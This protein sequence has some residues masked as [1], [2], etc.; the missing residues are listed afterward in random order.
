M[1]KMDGKGV[2]KRRPL[3]QPQPCAVWSGRSRVIHQPP[4]QSGHPDGLPS[5]RAPNSTTLFPR[6]SGSPRKS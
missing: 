5:R 6:R 3:A 4:E 1:R 2:K